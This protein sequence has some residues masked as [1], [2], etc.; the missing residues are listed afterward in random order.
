MEFVFEILTEVIMEPIIEGYINAMTRFYKG[1]KNINENVVK[2]CVCV[3]F[4]VL[5]PY[6]VIFITVAEVG[7]F[8]KCFGHKPCH[9]VLVEVHITNVAVIFLIINKIGAIFTASG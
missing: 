2:V 3:E 9:F 8:R 1:S 5:F 7:A 4:A 6:S